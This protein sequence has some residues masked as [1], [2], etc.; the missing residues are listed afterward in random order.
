MLGEEPLV[1][2]TGIIQGLLAGVL[3]CCCV[4]RDGGRALGVQRLFKGVCCCVQCVVGRAL[5]VS[6]T[7]IQGL[8][9]GVLVCCCV[10]ACYTAEPSKYRL[11]GD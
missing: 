5:G 8:V 9:A 10:N 2:L 11:H 7:N 6:N 3:L 1:D 4:V